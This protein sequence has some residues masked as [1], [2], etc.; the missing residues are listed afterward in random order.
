MQPGATRFFH[1]KGATR[2]ARRLARR[3]GAFV[4]RFILK[5]GGYAPKRSKKAGLTGNA[6]PGATCK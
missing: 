5:N 2:L 1:E 6:R 4:V 3:K